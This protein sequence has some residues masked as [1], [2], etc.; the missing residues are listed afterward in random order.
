MGDKTYIDQF[1]AEPYLC[2][3]ALVRSNGTP[4]IRPLWYLWDDDRFILSTRDDAIH[5]R[6]IRNNPNI[7][8]CVDKAST[9]YAGVVCEGTAE[10]SEGLGNDTALLRRLAERY[11]PPERVDPFMNRP[12]AQVD[13]RVRFIVRPQRWSLWNNDPQAPI[14]IRAGEY[15]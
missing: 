5:T 6:I 4:F 13:N 1:L 14:P 2:R 15:A 12:M 9:P 11:L 8:V 3:F 7:T 10:L